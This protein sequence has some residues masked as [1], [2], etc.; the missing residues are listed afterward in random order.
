MSCETISGYVK[1]CGNTV[2]W[3]GE[4]TFLSLP[5]TLKL[6]KCINA[7]MFL[8][9]ETLPTVAKISFIAV[10]FS[11]FSKPFQYHLEMLSLIVAGLGFIARWQE[12]KGD[13]KSSLGLFKV[14]CAVG[15]EGCTTYISEIKLGTA[16]ESLLGIIARSVGSAKFFALPVEERGRA[17]E[18]N[19]KNWFFLGIALSDMLTISKS[20]LDGCRSTKTKEIK[21]EK[22]WSSIQTEFSNGRTVLIVAGTISKLWLAFF[23]PKELRSIAALVAFTYTTSYY[24]Y[25]KYDEFQKPSAA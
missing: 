3:A 24:K 16:D 7:N 2:Y 18:A 6:M 10:Y 23:T 5:G 25:L 21:W 11:K 20:I 1:A 22:L 19:V 4:K 8:L 15:A 12:Y 13:F 9:K 14:G 17:V